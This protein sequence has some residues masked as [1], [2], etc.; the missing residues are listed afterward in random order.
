[1]D[2]A[3]KRKCL[4]GQEAL[5]GGLESFPGYVAGHYDLRKWIY[6]PFYPVYSSEE[7][8]LRAYS[9]GA[10]FEDFLAR[11]CVQV[12]HSSLEVCEERYWRTPSANFGFVLVC[13]IFFSGRAYALPLDMLPMAD[14]E[15]I[16][17]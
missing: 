10:S 3:D 5:E 16:P 9:A 6:A 15:G 14:L 1:M 13:Q 4:P 7:R 11:S 8:I 2:N 17:G 12:F